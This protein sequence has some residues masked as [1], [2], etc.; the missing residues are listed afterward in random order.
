[1]GNIVNQKKPMVHHPHTEDNNLVDLLE[2]KERKTYVRWAG[3]GF[4]KDK[5]ASIAVVKCTNPAPSFIGREYK[6]Y[7]NANFGGKRQAPASQRDA[8]IMA[9]LQGF[10]TLVSSDDKEVDTDAQ[11]GSGN[12]NACDMVRMLCRMVQSANLGSGW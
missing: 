4:A 10:E 5:N 3:R 1:M 8:I 9:R 7:P 12:A 11:T 2:K 6:S